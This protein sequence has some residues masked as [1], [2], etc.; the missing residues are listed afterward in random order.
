MTKGVQSGAFFSCLNPSC[1]YCS[2]GMI[3]ARIPALLKRKTLF[4]RGMHVMGT[5]ANAA[6][7]IRTMTLQSMGQMERVR[8]VECAVD[9][10][11][12][13]MDDGEERKADEISIL[14]KRPLKTVAFALRRLSQKGPMQQMHVVRTEGRSN[15]YRCG[16]DPKA[17]RIEG[18]KPKDWIDADATT[19]AAFHAM[20]S[21]SPV[22][23]H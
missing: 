11:A 10:V 9:S 14:L 16:P 2:L 6:D 22:V 3:R 12:A 4:Y 20:A 18:E 7:V 13:L 8:A 23:Y 1:R 21:C 5:T 17:A 19:I 15:I